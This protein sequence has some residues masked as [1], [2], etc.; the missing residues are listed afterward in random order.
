MAVQIIVGPPRQQDAALRRLGGGAH[1]CDGMVEIVDRVAGIGGRIL[2]AEARQPVGDRGLDRGGTILGRWAEAVLQIAIDGQ[3]GEPREESGI[4]DRLLTRHRMRPI[5]SAEG[6]G[7]RHAGRSQRQET[8]AL[9]QKR[10]GAVEGVGHDERVRRLM[11]STES[12]VELALSHHHPPTV[13]SANWGWRGG[14]SSRFPAIFSRRSASA[15]QW[16]AV[17]SAGP[18]IRMKRRSQ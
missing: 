18:P 1:A 9:E 8:L 4:V 16:C 15:D 2:D 3:V 10:R 13:S 5:G 17:S 12:F 14:R 11:Q 6:E 7:D